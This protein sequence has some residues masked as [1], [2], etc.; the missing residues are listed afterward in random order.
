MSRELH[1]LP[2]LALRETVLFPGVTVPLGVGRKQSVAAVEA[3]IEADTPRLFAVTQREDGEPIHP[4]NLYTTG[5]MVRIAQVNRSAES[6]QLVVQVEGRAH[7]VRFTE[8]DEHLTAL[9]GDMTDILPPSPEDK[10]LQALEK[11]LRERG[12]LL[13]T[14]TGMPE[15]MVRQALG[16]IDGVSRAW[17]WVGPPLSRSGPKFGSCPMML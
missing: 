17:V 2:V 8:G 11:E 14:K 3:A 9:V 10:L 1:T 7:A 6:I 16:S 5:V 13:A 12:L 15:P 4:S